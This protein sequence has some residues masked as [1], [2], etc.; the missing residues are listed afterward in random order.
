MAKKVYIFLAEGFEELEAVAVIDLLRR[1]GLAVVTVAVGNYLEVAG[2]HHISIR[3]D[4]FLKDIDSSD[5]DALILPGGLPGVTNLNESDVLRRMLQGGYTSG[6]LVAA[7][8][9][10]PMIL[11]QMGLL[12][13]KRATCYPG[14]EDHLRGHIPTNDRVIIDGQIIT[15]SGIGVVIEFAL[16]IITYLLDEQMAT[17]VSE[18]ILYIK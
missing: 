5:A 2:A 9:A 4:K 15:A 7:I 17:E 18:A 16:A 10:A 11:G 8:C 1:A 14:F 6:K 3:A 12:E 13:G